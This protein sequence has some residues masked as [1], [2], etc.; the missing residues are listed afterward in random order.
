MCMSAG[1]SGHEPSTVR[2]ASRALLPSLPPSIMALPSRHSSKVKH[3]PLFNTVGGTSV[4]SSITKKRGE[5]GSGLRLEVLTDFSYVL[6]T[7]H[8]RGHVDGVVSRLGRILFEVTQEV[9]H[10]CSLETMLAVNDLVTYGFFRDQTRTRKFENECTTASGDG[11]FCRPAAERLCHP[12]RC[13][14][15][16]SPASGILETPL[17][18]VSSDRPVPISPAHYY[19]DESQSNLFDNA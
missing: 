11:T 12:L 17:K 9:R 18:G 13:V 2:T 5:T 1:K 10:D 19:L 7:P 14:R 4:Y 6:R 15:R 8:L 16:A 3:S